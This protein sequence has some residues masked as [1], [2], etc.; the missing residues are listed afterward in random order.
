[1]LLSSSFLL[2]DIISLSDAWGYLKGFSLIYLFMVHFALAAVPLG[3][4]SS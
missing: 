3:P 2:L 1:M 4:V